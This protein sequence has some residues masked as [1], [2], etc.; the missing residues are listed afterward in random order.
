MDEQTIVAISEIAKTVT[1]VGILLMW[2]W[3]ERRDNESLFKIIE[4][5]TALR[6][7]QMEHDEDDKEGIKIAR[8]WTN[9]N[10]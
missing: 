2:V 4:A 10:Q 7:K 6:L 5:L 9:G 3:A 1:S 8:P